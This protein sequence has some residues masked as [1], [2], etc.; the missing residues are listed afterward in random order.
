VSSTICRPP[1]EATPLALVIQSK[2]AGNPFYM[3]EML[4]ASHRS[5][6]IWYDYRESRWCYD[7]DKMFEQFK[8]E[9]DYDVLD[10]DFVTRRL[11]ELPPAARSILAWASLIGGSF[12]FDLVCN[13]MSGEFGL[14]DSSCLVHEEV[15]LPPVYTKQDAV[16]GL[17]AAVAACVIV[18]CETDD[19]FRFTHDRYVQAASSLEECNIRE[20]HYF[21]ARTLL[22]Q[23]GSELKCRD[24]IASHICES[25][26]LVR[27]RVQHRKPFREHLMHAAVSAVEN[28]ARPT[29]AKYYSCA[30]TLL[31][32]NPWDEDYDETL[33]LHIRLGECYVFMSDNSAAYGFLDTIFSN[34]KS[35][36]DKAS[37]WLLKSR[38]EAQDGDSESA[39]TTLKESLVH[40]KVDFDDKPTFEKC[41]K[42]FMRLSTKIKS[43]DLS[44]VK[45]I[46]HIDP[47]LV[48]V[49]A[50]L[51]DA[52]SAAFWSDCLEFFN[53][54]LTMLRIH[55]ERGSFPQSG[56]AFLHISMIAL[57]RFDMIEFSA[58]M[59]ARCLELLDLL[60]DSFSSARGYMIYANFVSHIHAPL[61]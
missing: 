35:P 4:S 56:M 7:L 13:L 57:A 59:G 44:E 53:L 33:T 54:S 36:G 8:G 20:M 26:D 34:A 41:D 2:T 48:I 22:K 55:L 52:C 38:I 6:C 23:H 37:A 61:R 21:L 50:I 24:N 51:A 3:R 31:Q 10:D 17:Q 45:N 46:S 58:E 16:A 60:R 14:D 28:G 43:M 1:E 18:Q 15:R 42:E 29:A 30:V 39:L 49:G 40:L 25:V 12:S 19:R 27:R 47:K 5:R 11:S 32:E 9:H